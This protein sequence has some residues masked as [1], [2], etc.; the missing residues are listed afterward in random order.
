LQRKGIL[1]ADESDYLGAAFQHLSGLLLRQ[2][3][4]DFGR[5]PSDGHVPLDSLS[6]RDRDL[7][8]D[9]LRAVNRV[10]SRVRS[11]FVAEL[12]PG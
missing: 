2:Q 1:D 8:V 6:R 5:R 11:L 9:Y 12:A 4:D 7:T 10:R 3:V